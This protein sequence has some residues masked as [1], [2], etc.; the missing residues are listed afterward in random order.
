MKIV[1]VANS[2]DPDEEA[3]NEP[4]HLDLNSLPSSL[5]ILSII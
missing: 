1:E 3:H 5:C 4:S 2:I